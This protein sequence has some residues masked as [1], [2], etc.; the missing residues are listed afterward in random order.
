VVAN[1]DGEFGELL[2]RRRNELGL[3]QEDLA[4]KT[5][6]SIRAISDLE[7]GKTANPRR[8]SVRLLVEALR[9]HPLDHDENKN[10]DEPEPAATG[11]APD[12]VVPRQLPTT[13]AQFVGRQ[14]EFGKLSSVLDDLTSGQQTAAVA[15]ISGTAGVGKT[16]LAVH[17]AHQVA[18]R[19][20]DGQLYVDLRGFGP[21][22][23]VAPADALCGFLEALG[24]PPANIPLQ[25]QARA[26]LYRSLLA[27]RQVLVV[28]DNASDV[29]HVRSLLPAGAGCLAL[30]TS[31]NLLT[32]LAVAEGAALVNLDVLSDTDAY[33]LL[34]LR[35]GRGRLAGEPAAVGELIKL[36][37]GLPLALSITAA[38]ATAHP[39]HPLASLAAEFRDSH[40]R[41]EALVAGD[42]SADVRAAISWS[43]CRLGKTAARMFRLL[44]LHPGPDLSIAAAVS[45]S[46]A[47][48]I[49]T[50]RALAE[51]A[52]GGLVN[53]HA[54][55]RFAC[56]DLLRAYATEQS[57]D[58]DSRLSQQEATGRLLDHY[59]HTA[60]AAMLLTLP[61]C[62]SLPLP[63]RRPGVQPT[64]LEGQ[65][66]AAA[67]FAAEHQVLL[68]GVTMAAQTGFDD[69]AWLL[70]L[71]MAPHLYF[72]GHWHDW[73]SIHYTA[74]MSA[75]RQKDLWA[76]A[77]VHRRL[78]QALV[79]LDDLPAAEASFRFSLR[80]FCRLGDKAAQ[81]YTHA[82]IGLLMERRQWASAALRHARRAYELFRA[83]GI[84]L[85]E[86]L[87]LGDMAWD[88]NLLGQAD[89]AATCCLRAL[90]ICRETGERG[91]TASIL[92]S[93]GLAN[94]RLGRTETAI[95][96]YRQAIGEYRQAGHLAGE[97]RCLDELGDAYYHVGSLAE[98]AA[99]WG[100][101]VEI[102]ARLRHARTE[103]VRAK[104]TGPDL[105]APGA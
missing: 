58:S 104:L 29:D 23:P 65:A 32:G 6:F 105:A 86:A 37:A 92:D 49:A 100:Q 21:G 61:V 27:E 20:S 64:R 15:A 35:L 30:V 63:P 34:V 50:Q 103:S 38:R 48:L 24:V 71:V 62:E 81:A 95:G 43:Y 8:S 16:T 19:F 4:E 96:C 69:H 12:L 97:G 59:L 78:A 10:L 80:V 76:Q 45:L 85:G 99:A 18:D 75:Q 31:R 89:Q 101:A 91:L 66:E 93:L 102:L 87:A 28:L 9:L 42:R 3:T 73:A 77:S 5:G 94:L 40:G 47:S 17:W 46:G 14:A 33:D 1:G 98:A 83:T 72:S 7:R 84:R 54:P 74:L 36:T 39:G 68:T 44:G 90:E 70:P 57:R 2:R 22:N 53:E 79:F 41:L 52:A 56:H 13:T 11:V 51:L 67:W 26:G 55:G 60:H 88:Y 25:S 82:G